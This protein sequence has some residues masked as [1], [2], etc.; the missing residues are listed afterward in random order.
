MFLKLLVSLC[1]VV[2]SGDTLD[3]A[4]VSAQR[5]AAVASLSPVQT[6]TKTKIERLGTIG[7][8]EVI[9]QFSG[10]SIKDYGGIGGLKTV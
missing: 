10:V 7:L 3:V 8:H 1:C 9:S 6:I 2:P 5:N 4:T